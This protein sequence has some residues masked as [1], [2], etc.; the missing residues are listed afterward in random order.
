M[1]KVVNISIE[2][3]QT[4]ILSSEKVNANNITNKS[5]YGTAVQSIE[6]PK[7][8]TGRK[9][10]KKKIP[11][12]SE[13]KNS[14]YARR[15]KTKETVINTQHTEESVATVDTTQ[16]LNAS[17]SGKELKN[18]LDT[19]DAEMGRHTGNLS[20]HYK[21]T[22]STNHLMREHE[23][24]GVEN[25]EDP[26]TIE[27]GIQ[28]LGNVDSDLESITDDEIMSISRDDNEEA[29][30]DQELSSADEK[31]TDNILDE[32]INEANKEDTNVSAATTNET[33]GAVRRCKEIQNTKAPRS[34]S[35]PLGHF[36]RRMDFLTAQVHNVAKNLPTQL[37]N[38]FDSAASTIPIIISEALAQ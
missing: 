34:E 30:S 32:L 11:S 16:S 17:E 5:L 27:Y 3:E 1:L 7:T 20:L 21:F 36:P 23:I 33:L 13:R 35:D 28:S 24:K 2:H 29:D 6:Q 8:P 31:A 26:L 25:K 4:L 12:S 19:V 15:S 38:K 37:T 22:L 14:H 10:K 9:P 18:R